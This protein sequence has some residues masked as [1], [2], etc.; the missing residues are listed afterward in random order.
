MFIWEACIFYFLF[1]QKQQFSLLTVDTK[2]KERLKK[3]KLVF[4]I[5]LYRALLKYLEAAGWPNQNHKSCLFTSNYPPKNIS[6]FIAVLILAFS[7]SNKSYKFKI[8]ILSKLVKTKIFQK[9]LLG[10]R[11]ALTMLPSHFSRQ[12][13][14]MKWLNTLKT[15]KIL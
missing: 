11:M 7:K 13:V 10:L 5:L 3:M 6:G 12:N 2:R 9:L 14:K 4:D 8:L 1:W 15:A